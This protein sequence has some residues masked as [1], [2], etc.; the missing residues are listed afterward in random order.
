MRSL[1]FTLA[2]CAG[3]AGCLSPRHERAEDYNVDGV[4]LFQ[5]GAYAR[6]QESFQAALALK[7]DDAHIL[8]NLGE[9]CHRQGAF[10]EA[11]RYYNQCLDRE[12]NHTS[13]RYALA[14]LLLQ[15]GR[16]DSAA[17]MIQAWSSREPKNADA[18][19]LDGWYWHLAG[20][21]PRAQAR[22]QEA[23]QLEPHNRRGLIELGLIYEAMQRPD[24]AVALYERVLDD[25][26]NQLE[27]KQRLQELLAR[28]AG[29]P[30]PD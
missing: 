4:H 2:V 9:C 20:D 11:E 13:C 15:A 8:Y 22:L 18:I 27:V 24:R 12:P 30:K 29:A 10:A 1:K 25:D 17:G 5:H 26:P 6:A 7:P 3:L 14:Q 23:L 19:A 16:R 21:L 28:G